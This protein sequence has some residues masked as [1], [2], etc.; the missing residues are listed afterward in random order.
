MFVRDVTVKRQMA[1]TQQ[2]N[3]ESGEGG[4]VECEGL[5]DSGERVQCVV[6]TEWRECTA[7]GADRVER[8]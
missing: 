5:T 8:V 4:D 1:V 6:L 7:W 2:G 3:R